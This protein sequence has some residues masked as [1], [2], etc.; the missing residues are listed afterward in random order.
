MIF[1]AFNSTFADGDEEKSINGSCA[2][3]LRLRF[4]L[5]A[6]LAADDVSLPPS[7]TLSCFS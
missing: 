3:M 2:D 6:G 4:K 1:S 7:I 5:L